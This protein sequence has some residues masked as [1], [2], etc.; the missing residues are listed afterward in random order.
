MTVMTLMKRKISS[1]IRIGSGYGSGWCWRDN[2]EEIILKRL[3]C[4]DYIE[5][6]MWKRFLTYH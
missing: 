6:I 1:Q 5:E 3:Y 2:V 4:R